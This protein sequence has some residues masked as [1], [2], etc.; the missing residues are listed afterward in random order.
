MPSRN[1]KS[2]ISHLL[3]ELPRNCRETLEREE[4]K[5]VRSSIFKGREAEPV[6]RVGEDNPEGKQADLL[7][8]LPGQL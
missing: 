1:F 7:F 6:L 4:V 3:A 8:L 5:V 2:L